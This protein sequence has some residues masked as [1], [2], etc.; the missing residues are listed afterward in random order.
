MPGKG[1]FIGFHPQGWAPCAVYILV[2]RDKGLEPF[3]EPSAT[4]ADFA[5]FAGSSCLRAG[6][7]S[8]FHRPRFLGKNSLNP[9]ENRELGV[10]TVVST[11]CLVRH[12]PKGSR[13]NS[14]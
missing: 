14:A 5:Y 10:T 1:L 8:S 12:L 2:E 7:N 3:P 4:I 11:M 13:K 9:I 6:Q